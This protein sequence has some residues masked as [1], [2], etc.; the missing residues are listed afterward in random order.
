M[1]PRAHGQ[2]LETFLGFGQA[3]IV[4]IRHIERP[5]VVPAADVEGRNVFVFIEVAYDIDAHV[6]PV[7]VVVSVRH[8]FDERGLIVRRH[9]QRRRACAKR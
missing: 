3:G 7:G 4:Q 8:E 5:G 1:G 2:A 9:A 6:F